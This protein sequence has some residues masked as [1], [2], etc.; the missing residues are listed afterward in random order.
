MPPVACHAL[1]VGGIANSAT[2]GNAKQ[3]LSENNTNAES[4]FVSSTHRFLFR[5]RFGQKL[6]NPATASPDLSGAGT[7]KTNLRIFLINPCAILYSKALKKPLWAYFLAIKT[8]RQS[9]LEFLCALRVFLRASACNIFFT[10][11]R[12]GFRKERKATEHN[13]NRSRFGQKSKMPQAAVLRNPATVC[14]DL[15]GAGMLKRLFKI[16]FY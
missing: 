11:K 12:E 10:Q 5:C 13:R 3:F 4:V 7:P 15:S 2:G 16:L 9:C 6:V 14:P 1:G 8:L